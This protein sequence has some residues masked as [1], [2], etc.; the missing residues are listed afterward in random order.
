MIEILWNNMLRGVGADDIM[1]HMRIVSQW[2]INLWP[3]Y[4]GVIFLKTAHT[5]RGIEVILRNRPR[6]IFQLDSV[7]F[8]ALFFA[9]FSYFDCLLGI[10]EPYVVSASVWESV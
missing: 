3:S 10:L 8:S 4:S 7:G 2:R 1:W 5:L 9:L 6:S